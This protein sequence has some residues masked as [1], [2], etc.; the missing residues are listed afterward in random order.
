MYYLKEQYQLYFFNY[1]HSI[2]LK[3]NF[4][5]IEGINLHFQKKVTACH[6]FVFQYFIGVTMIAL[7]PDI[8]EIVT[9]IQFSLQNNISLR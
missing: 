5:V 6:H 9:G 3:V 1:L 7:V 4:M 2:V 8:P